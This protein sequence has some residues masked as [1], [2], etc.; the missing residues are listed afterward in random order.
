MS[1]RPSTYYPVKVTDL[2]NILEGR[3]DYT[4][5]SRPVI[6]IGIGYRN[7]KLDSFRMGVASA[8][9]DINTWGFLRKDQGDLGPIKAFPPGSPGISAGSKIMGFSKNTSD[10]GVSIYL[11]G[12]NASDLSAPY[13]YMKFTPQEVEY[14]NQPGIKSLGVIGSDLQSYH[15]GGSEDSLTFEV[16]WFDFKA[17]N[18]ESAL[19]KALKMVALSKG[20]GW[21]RNTPPVIMLKWGSGPS[22]PFKDFK[23][24]VEK[25]PFKPEQFT[26]YRSYSVGQNGLTPQL[27]DNSFQPLMVKQMIFLKR[28]E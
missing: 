9:S 20:Q 2:K 21:A 8:I 14:S 28:V 4:Y 11:T 18:P 22:T 6:D 1:D 7:E 16:T 26:K 17:D 24:V 3:Q 19:D 13:L 5:K 25:A 12:E 10:I 15:Y 27:S 23:F